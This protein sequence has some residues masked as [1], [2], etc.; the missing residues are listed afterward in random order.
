MNIL[1]NDLNEKGIVVENKL[2]EQPTIKCLEDVLFCTTEAYKAV[3]N[4]NSTIEYEY[5]L[6]VMIRNNYYYLFGMMTPSRNQNYKV[7]VDNTR[8][9]KVFVQEIAFLNSK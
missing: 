2:K 5:W 1:K 3:N 7:W 4:T 6:T 9:F 8:D